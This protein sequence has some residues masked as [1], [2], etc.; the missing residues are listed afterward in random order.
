MRFPRKRLS[1][2]AAILLS[3]TWLVAP[4]ASFAA[5][6]A[7]ANPNGNL[8]A[9]PEGDV[10]GQVENGAGKMKAVPRVIEIHVTDAGFD[11]KDYA[12]YTASGTSADYKDRVILK[13][14]G[15]LVHSMT[16]VPGD[17]LTQK[18]QMAPQCF[19]VCTWAKFKSSRLADTGG[20]GPGDDF[21]FEMVSGGDYHFTSAPDCLNGNSTPGFD[22]TPI[23]LHVKGQQ[24]VSLNDVTAGGT[25]IAAITDPDC[26]PNNIYPFV[27][28]AIG[29]SFCR[30]P[31]KRWNKIEGSLDKPLSGNVDVDID[32][33][34]GFSVTNLFIKPNTTVTWTNRG[35]RIHSAVYMSGGGDVSYTSGQLDSGGLTTGQSYSY[36][37]CPDPVHI[38][39]GSSQTVGSNID[40]DRYPSMWQL[41]SD[42]SK[43]TGMSLMTMYIVLVKGK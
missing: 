42:M 40:L 34:T 33:L 9:A 8:A 5:D 1:T 21:T 38:A 31:Y 28:P 10:V 30:L 24:P 32:D 26:I 39:C 27:D 13:N 7:K 15:Q 6:A 3:A 29:P 22:C 20:V 37:F 17:P 18:A 19:P 4:N 11:K 2:I 43:S 41:G 35:Q 12:V 25:G 16:I 14:D 23:V 36:T